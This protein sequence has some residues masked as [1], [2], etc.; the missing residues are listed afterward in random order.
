MNLARVSSV[1]LFKK[2]AFSLFYLCYSFVHLYFIYFCS[3]PYD[4]LPSTNLEFCLLFFSL[5]DLGIR[6][7]S[8]FEIFVHLFPEII[9]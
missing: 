8:L 7:S 3:E 5:V 4:F 6:L 9:L 2:P 1:Y